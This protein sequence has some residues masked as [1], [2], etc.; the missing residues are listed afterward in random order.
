MHIKRE[1]WCNLWS[2]YRANRWF[3]SRTNPDHGSV[4]EVRQIINWSIKP[5]LEVNCS[6][7]FRVWR[8]RKP[9]NSL[10]WHLTKQTASSSIRDKF[11]KASSLPQCCLFSPP[12]RSV[13]YFFC[14]SIL[15]FPYLKRLA[16]FPQNQIKMKLTLTAGISKIER[17]CI[18]LSADPPM[19]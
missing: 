5:I 1:P 18:L 7:D 9:I 4:T 2:W 10:T 13:V 3:C 19:L 16:L 6:S 15:C 12:E 8:R 14:S 11:L 17:A